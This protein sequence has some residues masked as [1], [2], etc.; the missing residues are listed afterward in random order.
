MLHRDRESSVLELLDTLR[1]DTSL[2]LPTV[3]RGTRRKL[4]L[5]ISELLLVR[6]LDERVLFELRSTDRAEIGNGNALRSLLDTPKEA[7]VAVRRLVVSRMK[8]ITSHAI[9]LGFVL[10]YWSEKTQRFHL[11]LECPK[12]SNLRTQRCRF[13][14]LTR[15]RRTIR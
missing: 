5:A 9:G 13:C 15:F 3:V 14:L 8:L 10:F 11:F 1:S 2:L 4:I 7:V 6:L 12:N